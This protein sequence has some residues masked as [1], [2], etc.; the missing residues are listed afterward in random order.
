MRALTGRLGELWHARE[1]LDQ[2]AR[3]ELNVRYRHSAL[4]FLWTLLTPVIMTAIFTAVFG[5][6][7]DVDIPDYPAF[8]LSGY[9]VWNFFQI[10]VQG[11]I[12]AITGNGSLIRKVYFPREVLPLSIVLSQGVHFLL[13]LAAVGP[14][15]VWSR[16]SDV[17]WHLPVVAVGFIL[18]TVLA[19]GLAMLFA[20]LNVT[21]RDLQEFIVVIFIVWFYATPVVY[22]Y[23]FAAARSEQLPALV[24]LIELNPMTW[25]VRLFRAGLYHAEVPDAPVIVATTF[26]AGA[27][28]LLG[29]LLFH[30]R[31]VTFAKEV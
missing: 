16:G 12:E 22:P 13:A 17:V 10:S 23:E 19:S 18:V 28:F 1:L 21:F 29:Y 27:V 4:G 11:S 24:T 20:A 8:F 26:T 9:L 3:K 30:Q 6:I 14:Y 5:V 15:L 2:L 7:L 31:A 25:F